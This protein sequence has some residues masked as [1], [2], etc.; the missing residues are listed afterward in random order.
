MKK[1]IIVLMNYV[2]NKLLLEDGTGIIL[3][4]T[5]NVLLTE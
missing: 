5:G 1:K 4:E 3:L 2:I